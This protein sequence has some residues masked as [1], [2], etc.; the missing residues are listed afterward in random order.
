MEENGQNIDI[1]E[2]E[3]DGY[4]QVVAQCFCSSPLL[5]IAIPPPQFSLTAPTTLPP[6][7]R[8]GP[9]GQHHQPQ[10]PKRARQTLTETQDQEG[11]FNT[12][13]V[14]VQQKNILLK[15]QRAYL[16]HHNWPRLSQVLSVALASEPPEHLDM[17]WQWRHR[18]AHARIS[19][20]LHAGSALM[21]AHPELVGEADK[22]RYLRQRSGFEATGAGK[23]DSFFQLVN[24]LIAQGH[25]TDALDALDSMRITTSSNKDREGGDIMTIVDGQPAGYKRR[26]MSGEIRYNRWCNIMRSTAAA[27]SSPNKRGG[28]Q[29]SQVAPVDGAS[30]QWDMFENDRTLWARSGRIGREVSE[31]AIKDIKAAIAVIKENQQQLQQQVPTHLV[32]KLVHLY[33]TQGKVEESIALAER[34]A[35]DAPDSADAHKLLLWLLVGQ[36]KNNGGVINIEANHHKARETN[37]KIAR[38][39]VNVLHHDTQDTSAVEIL[40][41]LLSG[42]TT[43]RG[44]PADVFIIGLCLYADT[45]PGDIDM[46]T[47]HHSQYQNV[48]LHIEDALQYGA[49]ELMAAKRAWQHKQ[50]QLG[51]ILRKLRGD[52]N[53]NND[54]SSNT[55]LEAVQQALVEYQASVS[56]WE[57]ILECMTN[58]VWWLG[59]FTE[60]QRSDTKQLD[61][62]RQL[63]LVWDLLS[64][65]SP[66]SVVDGEG[67]QTE[68][69]QQVAEDMQTLHRD[70]T[71][72]GL[73]TMMSAAHTKEHHNIALGVYN[74]ELGYIGGLPSSWWKTFPSSLMKKV[75]DG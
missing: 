46:S 1:Q 15:L 14:R 9:C 44:I 69:M 40:T 68:T 75:R 73:G 31:Q 21:E 29:S 26:A 20:H 5:Q 37:L 10:A 25:L 60:G 59:Y 35:K 55:Q 27:H 74:E 43:R 6:M 42:D 16:S 54:G 7:R 41:H 58:R 64:T 49:E 12:L 13:R 62:F 71:Q 39:C 45:L 52:N 70:I 23:I 47:D 22:Q 53:G 18:A 38:C 50:H 72:R 24:L 19:E 66:V 2:A 63:P 17:R 34:H 28:L 3:D 56:S 33:L 51:S 8:P 4:V 48:F 57:T 11:F 65:S 67:Y 30:V 36:P 61:I 32:Y